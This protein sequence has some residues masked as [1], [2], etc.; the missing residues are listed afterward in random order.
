MRTTATSVANSRSMNSKKKAESTQ[1]TRWGNSLA[2]R[3]PKALA[4]LVG[5]EES[6]AVTLT[7]SSKGDIVITPVKQSRRGSSRKPLTEYV[8]KISSA[9]IHDVIEPDTPQGKE[10]L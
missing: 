9:N 8:K 4:A 3:I 10:L 7:I 2:I 6:S 5:I 1:V